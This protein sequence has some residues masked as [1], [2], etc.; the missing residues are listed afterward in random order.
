VHSVSFG[1]VLLP[2]KEFGPI[3]VGLIN[4][5]HC[6]TNHSVFSKTYQSSPGDGRVGVAGRHTFQF[7][8]SPLLHNIVSIQ[9]LCPDC[10]RNW[11]REEEKK[12]YIYCSIQQDGKL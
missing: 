8:F 12:M 6:V 9:W 11:K 3:K 1:L 2:Y 10:G 7:H 5:V 4:D